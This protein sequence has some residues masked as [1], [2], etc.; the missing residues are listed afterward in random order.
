[1]E[2]DDTPSEPSV[3]QYSGSDDFQPSD[4][5]SS[6]DSRH[7]GNPENSAGDGDGEGHDE[8]IPVAV[9]EEPPKRTRKRQ[10]R[11]SKRQIRKKQRN[12]G[13]SYKTEK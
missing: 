9:Q 1:M 2:D 4:E 8:M 10:R 7:S 5:F 6:D 13:S 3:I 12:S 11:E